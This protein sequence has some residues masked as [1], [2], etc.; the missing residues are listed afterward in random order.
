MPG[1]WPAITS[2]QGLWPMFSSLLKHLICIQ[3]TSREGAYS[4]FHNGEFKSSVNFLKGTLHCLQ[5]CHD[6]FALPPSSCDSPG[7]IAHS[8]FRCSQ[9]TAKDSF[10]GVAPAGS[11]RAGLNFSVSERTFSPHE[12]WALSKMGFRPFL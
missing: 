2:S 9:R 1:C 12:V 8:C 4:P 11:A 6:L 10:A 5:I 7:L 3:S